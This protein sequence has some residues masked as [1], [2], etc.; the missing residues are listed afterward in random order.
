MILTERGEKAA[1]AALCAITLLSIFGTRFAFWGDEAGSFEIV[2][3]T[4]REFFGWF[5]LGEPHPPLYF[6][7]LKIWGAVFGYSEFAL[8]LPSVILFPITVYLTWKLAA[9][10]GLD[11]TGRL[12]AAACVA[13]HPSMWIFA[14]MARYYLFTAALFLLATIFLLDAIE[15]GGRR[16]IGCGVLVALTLWT[17]FPAFLIVPVHFALVLWKGKSRLT[18]WAIAVCCAIITCSPTVYLFAKSA[19]CYAEDSAPSAKSIVVGVVFTIYDFLIGEVRYPWQ[20]P[21]AAG[22]VAA[23]LLAIRGIIKR[24]RLTI[25]F[26]VLP[27]FIGA[28]VL[29]VFFQELPFIYGPARLL[30]LLPAAAIIMAA[31]AERFAPKTLVALSTI[32]L[33][34]YIWGISGALGGKDYR[35]S[36]YTMPCPEITEQLDKAGVE[37]AISRDWGAVHYIRKSMDGILLR[38]GLKAELPDGPVAHVWRSGAFKLLELDSLVQKRLISERGAPIDSIFAV[39][40]HSTI[41]SLKERFLHVDSHGYIVR[42][43][44]FPERNDCV[45]RVSR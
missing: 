34:G 43:F 7:L 9:R 38:D 42:V 6:A 12:F 23:A 32:L 14:R 37:A 3:G 4:W 26:G 35:N 19:W 17:D 22:L 28:L 13:L 30:L 36:V 40:E 27:I 18:H 8:R 1:V 29:A 24:P 5:M 15:R 44:I 39:P 10:F 45:P 2:S 11:R 16:W 41:K 20:V 25:L 33:I 21:T 31:G